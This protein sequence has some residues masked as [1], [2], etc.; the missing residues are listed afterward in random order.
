MQ[1]PE[2]FKQL[3]LKQPT[4]P[5][6]ST[7][8]NYVADLRYFINW[9][10]RTYS[11]PFSI[12]EITTSVVKD[13]S[14]DNAVSPRTKERHISAIKKLISLLNESGHQVNNP[15]PSVP[16]SS[17]LDY[18]LWKLREFKYYLYKQK[19]SPVTVKNYMSDISHF[20]KWLE[21]EKDIQTCLKISNEIISS[22]SNTLVH[23]L[24]LSPKSVNR[25]M[26]SIRKYLD[27]VGHSV[28]VSPTST[29]VTPKHRETNINGK[30]LSA[31][32]AFRI[33]D[34]RYSRIAPIK[35]FQ[36]LGY[37]YQQAEEK[38]AYRISNLI[39]DR[40]S[41]QFLSYKSVITDFRN[42]RPAW[43][44]TYHTYS[45][46][47][48][49]H[50]AVL[51]LFCSGLLIYGY[52]KY[53]D[54]PSQGDVLGSA[55]QNRKVLSYSG[56][57]TTADNTPITTPTELTFSIYP[58]HTDNTTVLWREA[59]EIKPNHDGSFTIQ[60]G[61]KQIL[62]NSF[63]TDNKDL[64]LGMKIGSSS[65][66]LPRQRLANVGYAQDAQMLH[67]MVPITQDPSKT[68]NT[69]LA[70]DSSGNLVLGG[71][72]NPVFSAT[73]GDFTISGTTT[74]LTTVAGSDGDIVL[75]PDGSGMIDIQGPIFNSNTDASSSGSV[76]FADEVVI[77]SDS[78]NTLFT[79]HN[80]ST[81]GDIMKLMSD[82][83]TRMIVDN[84][85]NVGI[86]TQTPS[87]LLHIAHESTPTVTI[88]NLVTQTR[89]D[90]S[91]LDT[92]ATV[93]TYNNSALGFK[94]N[95]LVR[96]TISPQGNVGIGT[97][98][99][100]ALLDVFGTASISGS[101]TF[102]GGVRN[103]Q[104]ANN[105]NLIIG[106]NTTGNLIL[107]PLNGSG[108]VGIANSNPEYKLDLLDNQ[109]SRSAMQI[110]NT[111]TSTDADGLIIRLGNK[112][113]ILTQ[114]NKFISFHTDGLGTLASI[115]G[116]GSGVAYKSTN[117]D[118]AEY[119]KK[120][121]NEDI[122]YGSLICLTPSN[123]VSKC[124]DTNTQ[125]IG[126]ASKHPA[127]IGGKDLGNESIE[128]GLVGQIETFVSTQNG[129]ISAGDPITLSPQQGVGTKAITGGM[130]VGRA[131][132]SYSGNTTGKILVL[133]QPSWHEP[134]ATLT[135]QGELVST[136]VPT[137]ALDSSTY[138]TVAM[139]LL[140]STTRVK[141]ENSWVSEVVSFATATIGRAKIGLI[142]S[143]N[144][145]VSGTLAARKIVVE[146]LDVTSDNIRIDG[147]S[148]ADYINSILPGENFTTDIAT[149][150]KISSNF[151]SPLAHDSEI[152]VSLEN[153]ALEIRNSQDATGT[154]VATIDNEG[155]ARFAGDIEAKTGSF[156]NATVSGTLTTDSIRAGTI[157]GLD[158]RIASYL[159]NNSEN[160]EPISPSYTTGNW[161]PSW[162][163][164]TGSFIDVGTMSAQF[165]M[166]HEN[167][168]SLGTATFREATV[169]DRFAIGTN[170]IFGP[171]SIDVLGNDIQIQPLRQGGI[172]FLSGLV[173]I[174]ANGNM[175]VGGNANFD[176]NV[177]IKGG[178]FANIISPLADHDLDVFLP[179]K[180]GTES[181]N[182]RIVNDEKLP[183]LTINEDGD[184][185]SSGSANFVGD[186]VASGS[187]F[188]SK[189]NIFSQDA[190]AVSDNEVKANSSA[191]TAI[192]KAYKREVTIN[193][194]HVT[195][196]SLIYITPS[197]NTGNQVLY[198]LRQSENGSFTV[199][200]NQATTRDIQFNWFVVN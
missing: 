175:T 76:D 69:I 22:Y 12:D 153:S 59:H 60:L 182:F 36:Q 152:S 99:P 168:L 31:L 178:L 190:Q 89:L 108:F 181:A 115:E 71:R 189:L 134:R 159:N 173:A 120:D 194:P 28:D 46:S 140:K 43:Y 45:I 11:K 61:R 144:A 155:N 93:G 21:L 25:K 184:V 128:V 80:T 84:S 193:T 176:Q 124:S 105:N 165:A 199:G 4:A 114:D 131:L 97:S 183:I 150:E 16:S 148:L 15:F 47:H 185:Y 132:Q 79:V 160:D 94:T 141:R 50:I 188:L 177:T 169:M 136:E 111:S 70:L 64:Y 88:E 147:K 54:I 30:D 138:D 82:N 186:L 83:I 1:L 130:I 77:A 96:F 3:L 29:P 133:V 98:N 63:F 91:A 86:G 2:L 170:F 187:A 118:L 67:G 127:F 73:G 27:F 102:S 51:T 191:G 117:A 101:L 9:F 158:E 164:E 13:F 58:H 198:L 151:I 14:Q 57:L 113:Q 143:Q 49:L 163:I 166:F 55:L 119:M 192:L 65:E 157:E 125:I 72:S 135:A 145:I 139:A 74:I 62:S 161:S 23:G 103:I 126:V 33:E 180:N 53:V 104:S 121:L 18:D 100:T 172:S 179:K 197:T 142:E 81:F 56:R 10:S 24:Q 137:V 6:E 195:E 162:Q 107:Q 95:N 66:L 85:G 171:D 32:E 8:K 149:A 122:P 17:S 37:I 129:P 106:G 35:L 75:K 68:A 167:L 90:F 19:A 196:D 7:V 112:N 92:L 34:Q 48:Y 154:A 174:D 116:N 41:Q 109:A 87:Q 38:A 156:E 20:T 44:R 200:V 52:A 110:Y 26:S 5:S 39:P 42:K 78:A 40:S 146:Q 123:T